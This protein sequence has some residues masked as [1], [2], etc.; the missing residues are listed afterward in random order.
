[1]ELSA[2]IFQNYKIQFMYTLDKD[3][4]EASIKNK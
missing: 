2:E 4:L 1:M 3:W